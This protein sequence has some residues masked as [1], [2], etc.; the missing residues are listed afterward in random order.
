MAC[1]NGSNSTT[2]NTVRMGLEDYFL[3]LR[4]LCLLGAFSFLLRVF[5]F[6]FRLSLFFL[7]RFNTGMRWGYRV[8]GHDRLG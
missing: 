7:G 4:F 2:S 1:S 8:T 5:L 3:F 6:I